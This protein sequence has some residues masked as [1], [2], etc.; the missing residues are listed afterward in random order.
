[1]REKTSGNLPFCGNSQTFYQPGSQNVQ[2]RHGLVYFPLASFPGP[3]R[4]IFRMG[5]GNEANFQCADSV[6]PK[7][8]GSTINGCTHF[9]YHGRQ[10]GCGTGDRSSGIAKGKNLH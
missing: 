1:M 8:D 10:P 4:K 6:S 7:P 9:V 3:I 5:P 2:N